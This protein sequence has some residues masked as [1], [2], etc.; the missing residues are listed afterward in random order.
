MGYD[1]E[2]KKYNDEKGSF[3]ASSRLHFLLCQKAQGGS[4]NQI[5]EL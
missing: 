5:P 3:K 1:I 4:S 2:E